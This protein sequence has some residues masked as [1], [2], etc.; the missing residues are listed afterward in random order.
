MT[1]HGQAT[2]RQ[3]GVQVSA[4]VRSVNSR[5]MKVTIFGDLSAALQSR[6]EELLRVRIN[7]GTINV[8]IRIDHHEDPSQFKLN[9]FA[10]R[11]YQEQLLRL[12]PG[13][14]VPVADLL[15]LPGVCE[16]QSAD[17]DDDLWP[18]LQPAVAQAIDRL[19][20]MREAEG[21]S[22]QSNL[23]DN[24]QQLL[25]WVAEVE[26]L[27]PQIVHAY[28]HRL[29]DRIQQLLERHSLS[30][31]PVDVI[32]EVGI[33]AERVDV[34]EEMVR[35][36]SHLEQ[37]EAT[38]RQPESNGRKLEFLVQEILRETN[39]IGSK[40]NHATIAQRVVEMKTTIERIREMIQ[41]VE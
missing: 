10:L 17:N 18:V 21:R 32:R 28:A 23:S 19:N 27:S 22:M 1:G 34:S 25:A 9:E 39:T 33:M 15:Q 5:F 37:F 3:A 20:A 24:C 12:F 35:L 30:A 16:G 4:E 11:S 38:M 13:Q 7:R 41:N 26:Q 14:P 6:V 40:V 2:V 8:R 29:T 36:R 31:A